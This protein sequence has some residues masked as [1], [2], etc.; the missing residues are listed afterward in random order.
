MSILYDM[1]SGEL[2]KSKLFNNGLLLKDSIFKGTL[3][4]ANFTTGTYKAD[5]AAKTFADLFTF[6]RAGKAWLVK[7]TGLQE[8]AIDVP[9]FDR[10]LLI[11]KESTCLNGNSFLSDSLSATRGGV[12]VTPN[13]VTRDSPTV[14]GYFYPRPYAVA[15]TDNIILSALAK[16]GT[17]MSIVLD[18]I[19][20]NVVRK[21]DYFYLKAVGTV[22]GNSGLIWRNTDNAVLLNFQMERGDVITSPIKTTT[23]PVTRP[24]DFLANKI[25]GTTVTGDWD[26]TLTLSI[27]AGELVHSGYGRIRS[28]EIN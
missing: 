11:E 12:T 4:S 17:S 3:L 26:S 1:R 14:I 10:G 6:T 13:G 25:T 18:N 20:I 8:Y 9:R 16:S 7:D 21:G 27:V 23:S 2:V 19:S 28:L 15:E 5:G 24:A 22:G